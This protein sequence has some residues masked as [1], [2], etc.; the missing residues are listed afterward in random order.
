M[1]T[2]TSFYVIAEAWLK[3][4]CLHA[5]LQCTH[6]SIASVWLSLTLFAVV[7]C[8]LI[9]LARSLSPPSLSPSLS[10]SL[11]PSLSFFSPS[12]SPFS[13]PLSLSLYLSLSPGHYPTMG[14]S[15]HPVE[16]RFHTAQITL[17]VFY[18][19]GP[20]PPNLGDY[21][22]YAVYSVT[23]V[24]S[25]VILW[26][27][28]TSMSSRCDQTF[29][30]LYKESKSL[31]MVTIHAIYSVTAFRTARTASGALHVWSRPHIDQL[32]TF[33]RDAQRERRKYE[34][35]GT[36][37]LHAIYDNPAIPETNHITER[38]NIKEKTFNQ[39]LLEHDVVSSMF[40]VPTVLT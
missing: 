5:T 15:L 32:R 26:R 33:W 14:F 22:L 3:W 7:S 6:L 20:K 2:P 17:H 29:V 21:N 10:L 11:S 16:K 13:L 40:W 25:N 24:R 34:G 36:M 38:K 18:I 9:H 12:L 39:Q 23:F 8:I 4:I 19:V 37:R 28:H 30:S 35:D 1:G 27:H 31:C